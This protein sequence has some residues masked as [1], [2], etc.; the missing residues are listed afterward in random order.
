MVIVEI[1]GET[2]SDFPDSLYKAKKKL[3]LKDRFQN[4][5]VCTKC[6][7]L[8]RRQDV[9]NFYD[10]NQTIMYCQ[11]IEFPN[12]SSRSLR[13][14][15]TPLFRQMVTSADI[16]YELIFLFAGIR[17]QLATMFR[18]PGFKKLLRHWTNRSMSYDILSD[19]YNGQV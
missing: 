15:N 4:F 18:R 11:H 16:Q 10:E 1:G 5:V 3:S 6:H 17:Q 2:F 9:K 19:I 7:K 12:S 13:P 14:C 8:Y